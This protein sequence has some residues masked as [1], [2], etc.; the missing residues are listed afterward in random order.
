MWTIMKRNYKY[1]YF[2][3][4]FSEPSVQEGDCQTHHWPDKELGFL[5]VR[6]REESKMFVRLQWFVCHNLRKWARVNYDADQINF[7]RDVEKISSELDEIFVRVQAKEKK[8]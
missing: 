5:V 8:I 6:N 4:F 2:P 1:N 7:T 3:R